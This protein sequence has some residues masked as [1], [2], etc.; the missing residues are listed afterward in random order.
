MERAVEEAIIRAKSV[1]EMVTGQ[2][3]PEFSPNTPYAR[4][5]PEVDR[6][7]HVLRN[8]AALFERI[9]ELGQ[10]QGSSVGLGADVAVQ[11]TQPIVPETDTNDFEL[12][13]EGNELRFVFDVGNISRERIS[14]ELQGV[15]LR[16]TTDRA[17]AVTVDNA[18]MSA[19][20]DQ[21]NTRVAHLPAR[22]EANAV[23]ADL[24]DSFLTV[25]VRM[26]VVD[27]VLHK[28]EIR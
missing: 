10:R 11:T 26:P 17:Q 16:V 24:K 6:E 5:P 27:D 21:R 1:Y 25:R 20:G 9:R 28:I 22:V 14:V 18:D 13:R 23:K 8:A 15:M 4:I 12:R 19:N 2:Q 7:E 3:A